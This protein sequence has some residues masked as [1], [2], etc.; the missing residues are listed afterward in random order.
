MKIQ[1]NISLL[2]FNTFRMDVKAKIFA[3]YSSVEEL[4]DRLTGR[5]TEAEDVIRARLQTA[6][7]ESGYIDQYEYI[8]CNENGKVEE[9]VDQIHHIVESRNMLVSNQ[10]NFIHV[11]KEEL[12]DYR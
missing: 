6:V 10:K 3:E 4:K 1:E 8:V 9:C 5:G 11:L 12:T 7:R 2:P